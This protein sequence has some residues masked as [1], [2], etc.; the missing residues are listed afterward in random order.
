VRKRKQQG[1][2]QSHE[3]WLISYADFITLLF[4]FFVVLYASSRVDQVRV[5][6]MASALR[7]AF[8]ELGLFTPQARNVNLEPT[9]T[10]YP[11]RQAALRGAVGL[12]Q[13]IADPASLVALKQRLTKILG[14][15]I[16]KHEIGLRFGRGG[17]IISLEELGFFDSGSAMLRPG[18]EATLN[19]IALALRPLPNDLSIEGHTDN[20]P[21]HNSLFASN[22]DLSA[23]RAVEIVRLFITQYQFSPERLSAAGYS[24]YHPIAS[25]ST[26]EG[27]QLNRRVDVVVKALPK[28]AH[29]ADIASNRPTSV[30]PPVGQK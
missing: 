26:P 22:W 25:N 4:A 27:R 29:A 14:P 16:A 6:E 3:R 10:A 23:A 2:G 24:E 8:Q 7:T 28:S 30:I 19:R 18:S 13:G 15:E 17:L 1:N 11:G 5:V 12:S 20:V 9:P 21:I